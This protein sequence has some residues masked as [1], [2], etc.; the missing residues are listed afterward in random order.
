[1]CYLHDIFYFNKDSFFPRLGKT[2]YKGIRLQ[3]L[4]K[5]FRRT[6]IVNARIGVFGEVGAGKTTL[7]NYITRSSLGVEVGSVTGIPHETRKIQ[8]IENVTLKVDGVEVNISIVD[9]P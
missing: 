2:I 5:L 8:E 4:Q 3:L 6:R 7:V 9:T 1:M